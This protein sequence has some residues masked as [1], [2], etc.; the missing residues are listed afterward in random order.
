MEETPK[1]PG[2]LEAL[3]HMLNRASVKRNLD[4]TVFGHPLAEEVSWGPQVM[5][6]SNFK[7]HSFKELST[8]KAA[9][10]TS[11]GMYAF[12][13]VFTIM[14]G[15]FAFLPAFVDWEG[16][17]LFASLMGLLF[18]GVGLYM[19]FFF[20]RNKVF[21]KESGYYYKGSLPKGGSLGQRGKNYVALDQIVAIQILDENVS[22][23]ESSYHSYEINLVLADATRINVV[24]HSKTEQI[25][26]DADKLAYFLDLPIWNKADAYV[27][28]TLDAEDW[29]D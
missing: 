14:G 5:G 9:F 23:N 22:G 6:G 2:L 3:T 16:S 12:S 20:S 29:E 26:D 19:L 4:L 11:R 7:T 17:A 21:D 28:D 13:L 15:G 24:D 25:M 10:A 27:D 1:R 18:F 8:S